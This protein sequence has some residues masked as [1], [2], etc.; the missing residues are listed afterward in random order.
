MYSRP[1]EFAAI[2]KRL[3]FCF[4]IFSAFV[5]R[6]NILL[7]NGKYFIEL[8]VNCELSISSADNTTCTFLFL[9]FLFIFY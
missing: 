1:Q 2:L 9:F 7:S 4:H 5:K 3:L 6:R 8:V